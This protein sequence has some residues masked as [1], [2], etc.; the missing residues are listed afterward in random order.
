MNTP[1]GCAYLTIDDM[2]NNR[3][4]G[5]LNMAAASKAKIRKDHPDSWVAVNEGDTLFGTI[6]DVVSAWSDVRGTSGGFY[7]LLTIL[8]DEA[9][10]YE[11]GAEVKVHCFGAVLFNEMRRHRPEV[12]ERI[13]I[14]YAGTSSKTPKPGNNPAELYRV[15]C[16]DRHDQAGRAYS[17]IFGDNPTAPPPIP[18]DELAPDTEGLPY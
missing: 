8:V 17:E 1:A 12:G 16:P 3:K 5:E 18:T 11:H 10:G 15:K 14:M 13:T 4:L 9:D 7:P 6:T 2:L